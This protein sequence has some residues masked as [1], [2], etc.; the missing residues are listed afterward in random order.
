[1]AQSSGSSVTVHSIT[2]VPVSATNPN[3]RAEADHTTARAIRQKNLFKT[4]LNMKRIHSLETSPLT[5]RQ[6]PIKTMNSYIDFAKKENKKVRIVDEKHDEKNKPATLDKA[7][8]G[9]RKADTDLQIANG[10]QDDISIHEAPSQESEVS[11]H[12]RLNY[13][14][15]RAGSTVSTV[16]ESVNSICEE[17]RRRLFDVDCHI[18]PDPHSQLDALHEEKED[19]E[20]S[21]EDQTY[22]DITDATD[23]V[24]SDS[25]KT[26]NGSNHP[27]YTSAATDDETNQKTTEQASL[28]KHAFL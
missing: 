12:H 4:Q 1:M 27:S 8:D 18:E 3:S 19:A 21:G 5:R 24:S 2:T 14:H 22:V 20:V 23:A 26:E 17:D 7:S 10:S 25:G 15:S 13:G 6:V 28:V 16:C 11:G 9:D